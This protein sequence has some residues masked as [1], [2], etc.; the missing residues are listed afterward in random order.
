MTTNW[1]IAV[2]WDR[3]GNYTGQYD[4]VTQ[5]VVSADW[6]LGMDTAYQ[7]M[8]DN[9]ILTLVLNN[10]DKRFS[11]EY[12]SGPLNGLLR[13]TKPVR[14]QSN[15]GSTTRTHWVGWIESI[16][17]KVGQFGQRTVEIIAT[18]LMQFYKAAET[19]LELQEN[20]RT[21]QIID[22]LIDEVSMPS[23][24]T[25]SLQTGFLTLGMAADNWVRHSET[26]ASQEAFD[27]YSAIGDITA[28][29]RGKFFFDREGRAR[30]WNRHYLLDWRTDWDTPGWEPPTFDD[31]MTDLQYTYAGLEQLKNEVTVVAHP[32]KITASDV[33][34]WDLGSAII[35]VEPGQTRRVYAAYQDGS[36]NRVGGMGVTIDDIEYDTG[37]PE[38]TATVD[39]K[40]TGSEIVL[41]NSANSREAIITKLV[42][43]GRKI[44]EFERMEVTLK[45]TSSISDYGRRTL[46]LNLPS[47]DNLKQAN[48]IAEFERDRR[49]NPKGAVSAV[50]VKCHGTLAG[51]GHAHQLARTIGD[52]IYVRETQASHNGHYYIIGEAHKLSAGATLWETTWYLE[53]IPTV[54]PWKLGH[55]TLSKLGDTTKLAY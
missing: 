36:G 6:F 37:S 39:E 53:P 11:P 52:R 23:A 14:I 19:K 34:L 12:S 35:T 49:C 32:R 13:P 16:Q 41:N 48:I 27:V 15:D 10:T 45:A 1:T 43:K 54:Y 25:P 9:S 20:K 2:D 28:A 47:I 4:D 29:E 46:R 51:N 33:T 7:E 21:D 31:S 26:D 42:L 40:A 17:P 44:T 38:L 24:P 3:N 18:G 30:F 55:S 5:Y 22:A 8:A 50:T